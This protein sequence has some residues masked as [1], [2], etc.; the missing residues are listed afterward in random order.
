METLKL[1]MHS[2]GLSSYDQLTRRHFEL[3]REREREVRK[4]QAETKQYTR[5]L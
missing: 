3:L 1:K 5:I 2:S 4:K